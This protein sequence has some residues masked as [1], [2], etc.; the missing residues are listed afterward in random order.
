MILQFKNT[1]SLHTLKHKRM[2]GSE[3]LMSLMT[4]RNFIIFSVTK[5][6]EALWLRIKSEQKFEWG[7]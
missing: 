3:I 5:Y 4:L 2:D 7:F 6:K 1:H